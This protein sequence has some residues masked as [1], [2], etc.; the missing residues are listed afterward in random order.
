MKNRFPV[1]VRAIASACFT[2]GFFGVCEW[3]LADKGWSG[4]YDGDAGYDWRL[5]PSLDLPQVSHVEMGSHFSVQTNEKGFRT[6]ALPEAEPWILAL[7]CSTT[8]GWGVEAEQAWPAILQSE[9]GI[10][11]FNAGVPGHST[12]QGRRVADE[13]LAL[14]PT[15]AI[16]GWGLRDAQKTII[17]DVE[18]KP[19]AFPRNTHLF[20]W[21]NQKLIVPAVN[22]GHTPRVSEDHFAQNL[23]AMIEMAESKGI[24]VLLLDMTGRSD[25]PGHG[26][27]LS[28]MGRPV[29]V[30]QLST[31]MVFDQD[32]IHLN[33]AGNRA[34][35]QLLVP[36]VT[37]LIQTEASD[38]PAVEVPSQTP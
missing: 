26:A 37:A 20:K 2:V 14:H 1:L 31:A 3:A 11:V 29:V 23:T 16:L 5:K 4:L 10:P 9:L 27:V 30:P 7:G 22:R 8:F 21:L 6:A 24:K 36:P 28:K 17:P 32:P 33:I 12:V 38:E 34:L 35:A 13:L 25:T 15:L 19:A 18:R